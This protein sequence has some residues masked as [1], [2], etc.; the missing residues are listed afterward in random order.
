MG[1]LST[2]ETVL[3]IVADT[4]NGASKNACEIDDKNQIKT[5]F[6]SLQI[7]HLTSDGRV[8]KTTA[9][10]RFKPKTLESFDPTTQEPYWGS[11]A[12]IHTKTDNPN[13]DDLECGNRFLL[14]LSQAGDEV[15]SDQTNR[16][17]ALTKIHKKSQDR[18]TRRTNQTS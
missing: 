10:E 8:Q 12:M 2:L 9:G 5:Q 14:K 11:P 7:F 1:E 3:E 16:A 13:S 15:S 4:R 18:P 17:G 6:V